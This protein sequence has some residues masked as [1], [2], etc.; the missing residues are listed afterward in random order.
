MQENKKGGGVVVRGVIVATVMIV[1]VVVSGTPVY[2]AFFDTSSGKW[3]MD[4]SQ[5]SKSTTTGNNIQQSGDNLVI[6]TTGSAGHAEYMSNWGL[7]MDK[8]ASFST[9]FYYNPYGSAIMRLG[10]IPS[11]DTTI[12]GVSIGRGDEG[13]PAT[14]YWEVNLGGSGDT[15]DSQSGATNGGTFLFNYDSGLQ[16]ITMS[17]FDQNTSL[18]ASK[19]Y[20][21]S[22][23]INYG[24]TMSVYLG[25]SSHN[26]APITSDPPYNAYFTNFQLLDGTTPSGVVPEPATLS[27]L[28]LGLLGFVFKKKKIA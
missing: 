3:W 17:A 4:E 13:G 20:D 16:D 10:L 7:S 5:W 27:L 19:T 2:A 18:Q 28:G 12:S 1:M 24:Q 23:M 14:F 9:G 11:G 22:G 21:L 26:G 15:Q 6:T 8:D 25:A